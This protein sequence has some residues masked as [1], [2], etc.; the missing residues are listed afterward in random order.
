VPRQDT[1]AVDEM[2]KRGLKVNPVSPTAVVE[3]RAAAEQF[4]RGMRGAMIPVDIL[5]MAMRERD[6]FRKGTAGGAR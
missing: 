2:R 1:P 4:A 3:W 6:A 5:E